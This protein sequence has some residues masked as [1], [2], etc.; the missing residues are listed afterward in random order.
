MT[1]QTSQGLSAS[2]NNSQSIS[3]QHS[4]DADLTGSIAEGYCHKEFYEVS[5]EE[6]RFRRGDEGE[7]G[8]DYGDEMDF[9]ANKEQRP[10][11]IVQMKDHNSSSMPEFS[12]ASSFTDS[13][14]EVKT[15]TISDPY[16]NSQIPSATYNDYKQV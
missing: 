11:Q 16:V 1:T 4:Q 3:H 15:N 13:R 5:K 10:L 2:Y 9:E 14:Q 12:G 8:D 6:D 7:H